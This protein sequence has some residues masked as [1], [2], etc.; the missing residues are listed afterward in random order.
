MATEI[1]RKNER[2]ETKTNGKFVWNG[3][4]E[5]QR[6]QRRSRNNSERNKRTMFTWWIAQYTEKR[7]SIY[8]LTGPWAT[9]RESRRGRVAKLRSSVVCLSICQWFLTFAVSSKTMFDAMTRERDIRFLSSTRK[10]TV[11]HVLLPLRRIS[12]IEVHRWINKKSFII[13]NGSRFERFA[14]LSTLERHVPDR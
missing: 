14:V 3:T 4:A 8:L 10:V 2:A 9:P 12:L 5:K 1:R 11:M 13:L 6:E 7:I